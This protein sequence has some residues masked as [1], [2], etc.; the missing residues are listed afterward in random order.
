MGGEVA[1]TVERVEA[2]AE[3]V[4]EDLEVERVAV[5]EGVLAEDVMAA[6]ET[7]E[8]R[9]RR[10]WEDWEVVEMAQAASA[11][12]VEGGRVAG[13]L[14]WENAASVVVEEMALAMVTEAVAVVVA[15]TLPR[16]RKPTGHRGL[17]LIA[18]RGVQ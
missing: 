17:F 7:A 4:W 8:A 2:E 18:E 10:V 13:T 12:V 11:S 5:M 6:A 15:A 1:S 16:H 3:A 14:G 9:A